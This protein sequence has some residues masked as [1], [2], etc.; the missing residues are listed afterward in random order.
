MVHKYRKIVK[1]LRKYGRYSSVR[2][3]LIG[4]HCITIE[5]VS[6]FLCDLI[7]LTIR[8][9]PCDILTSANLRSFWILVAHR[10]GLV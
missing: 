1:I 8:A 6:S 5:F 7:A 3:C 9:G 10:W 4:A 2:Q